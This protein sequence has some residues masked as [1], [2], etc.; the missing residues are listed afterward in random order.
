MKIFA[1]FI[2]FLVSLFLSVSAFSQTNDFYLVSPE[3]LPAKYQSGIEKA[4]RYIKKGEVYLEKAA[5][6]QQKLQRYQESESVKPMKVMT[7]KEGVFRHQLKASSYFHDAHRT[8]FKTLKRYLKDEF[9]IPYERIYERAAK[10]FHR[11][12]VLRKRGSEAVPNSSPLAFIHEAVGY[13]QEALEDFENVYLFGEELL[14][15]MP[16]PDF[17]LDSVFFVA[18][19][20]KAPLEKHGVLKPEPL[21][22]VER[23]I[24]S[25]EK[26]GVFF[27][28]Q[29]LATKDPVSE[30][31]AR[32]VYQGALPLIKSYGS[33]WHRYS[34]G[35]FTSVEEA[36]RLMKEEGIYGFVIAF[37]G[38]ERI[39]I[40]KAKQL[41]RP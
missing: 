21:Q 34:A 11:G 29:F 19:A 2:F 4:K 10:Q 32:Q 35:R 15:S 39:S 12:S 17:E 24:V 8:E 1:Q 23:S 6:A 20:I 41:M 33:G 37:K 36:S 7:L 25:N 30:I 28:I 14:V 40:K 9:P 3:L 38:D 16:L 26:S 27:S 31:K 13:E 5:Q 22:P 18:G